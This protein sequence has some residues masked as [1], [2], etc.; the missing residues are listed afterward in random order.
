[1]ILSSSSSCDVRLYAGLVFREPISQNP[2]RRN[3]GEIAG[4]MAVFGTTERLTG[5]CALV[6]VYESNPV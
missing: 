3:L 6:F 2:L 5:F 4:F 1:M